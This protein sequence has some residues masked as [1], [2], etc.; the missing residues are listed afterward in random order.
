M[1]HLTCWTLGVYGSTSGPP[2]HSDGAEIMLIM[3][4]FK[5]KPFCLYLFIV[6]YFFDSAW[7]NCENMGHSYTYFEWISIMANK[8][9]LIT[10]KHVFSE[11]Y[12]IAP[13]QL[14]TKGFDMMVSS[15]IISRKVTHCYKLPTRV[16]KNHLSIANCSTKTKKKCCQ[17][18]FHVWF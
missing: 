17:T 1:P 11:R 5:I 2:Q 7:W 8:F 13:K 9:S 12:K 6:M 4:R 15:I 3:L 10:K 18:Q 14:L 16:F